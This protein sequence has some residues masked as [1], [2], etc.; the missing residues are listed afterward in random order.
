MTS[1]T[2]TGTGTGGTRR[3]GSLI[4]SSAKMA[5]VGMLA[6]AATIGF[7]LWIQYIMLH[8]REVGRHLVRDSLRLEQLL[9]RTFVELR[10]WIAYG[11][12]ESKAARLKIWNEEIEPPLAR[13][14]KA[15]ATIDGERA[16][17]DVSALEERLR[18]LRY[19]QW[20]VEDVAH[21]SSN[22]RPRVGYVLALKP[23]SDEIPTRLTVAAQPQSGRPAVSAD[24]QRLLTSFIATDR[25]MLELLRTGTAALD[26]ESRKLALQTANIAT[27]LI[28]RW[29]RRIGEHP[30]IEALVVGAKD[31][32]AY[33]AGVPK[34]A[35]RR[36]SDDWN[37]SQT[38]YRKRL[39]PLQLEVSA[40]AQKISK[41][42][43][44]YVD[45]QARG[46]FR[47]SFVVLALALLLG[48]LSIAS[49]YVN[50]RLE[51]RVQRALAKASSL[52][53]YV[54]E[55]RIG[56][57]GMG[58]VFRAR[59]ALLRR[60][61]AVKVL[62]LDRA[63]D[64]ESQERFQEEVRLTSQLTHPNTIAIFD[65]GRTPEGLFYYAMELLDGVPLDALVAASGPLPPARVVHILR[66]ICGSLAEAHDQGLL[67]RDIK[68][69]NVMLAELG[70]VKDWAKVLDFGLVTRLDKRTEA[71]ESTNVVGTPAYLAPEAIRS[72]GLVG[73]RSDL[74]AVGAV[75][76]FLLCGRNVFE[77]QSVSEILTAHLEEPPE[78]PSAKLGA[79][80]PESL[81]LLV[82]ACLA[83]DPG[84]RP[85]NAADLKAMLERVDVEPWTA[86]QAEIW[87]SS[88]G[89]AVR[90]IA[91]TRSATPTRMG[92]PNVG[93]IGQALELTGT[94]RA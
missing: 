42:Q 40:L 82:L 37:V 36:R 9:H 59:H 7:V 16:A 25:A 1:T 11:D 92:R 68:P 18:H 39:K 72:D 14:R 94:S 66:Q 20:Y 74:Y 47:W 87:W 78:P 75:G 80:L 73:P 13:L 22:E 52:G 31:A 67:H 60:P 27:E 48:G 85:R 8:Q 34:V 88:Y 6:A 93:I 56:G 29:G 91:Q 90:A 41:G 86:Q 24:A 53:K 76:Y 79:P 30:A 5:I 33:A 55:E 35:A 61:S 44:V 50:Y 26:A 15:T 10:G 21:A 51:Y 62:R 19:L 63:L 54:I 46:L 38:L 45:R 3:V 58:E 81:E 32:R 43:L 77:S 17:E 4:N 70:G 12:P 83:K 89:E 57:G 84:E 64:L 49:L 71:T 28:G 23:L 2:A 65:Y 69:S